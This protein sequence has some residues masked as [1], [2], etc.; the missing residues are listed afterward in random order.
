MSEGLLLRYVAIV[1][2]H[3]AGS[4]EMQCCQD[5]LKGKPTDGGKPVCIVSYMVFVKLLLSNVEVKN[6]F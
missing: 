4:N 2:G 3:M 5:Q 1:E 6:I